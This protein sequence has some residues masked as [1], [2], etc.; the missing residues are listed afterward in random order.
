MWA[1]G[2]TSSSGQDVRFFL[3]LGFFPLAFFLAA[4]PP[5]RSAFSV[6]RV[7]C[8]ALVAFRAALVSYR[9]FIFFAAGP[10]SFRL[11]FS[12][13]G[14]GGESNGRWFVSGVLVEWWRSVVGSKS[15]TTV[16]V[17]SCS[18]SENSCSRR[19][20]SRS[21]SRSAAAEDRDATPV[22]DST[23]V[24][25]GFLTIHVSCLTREKKRK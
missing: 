12:R 14:G 1:V 11:A 20:F 4:F 24:F 7:R 3:A 19:P 6:L 17:A 13:D 8:V 22:H 21:R 5:A 25:Q 16:T 18:S 2:R 9:T 23:S 15:S 10:L